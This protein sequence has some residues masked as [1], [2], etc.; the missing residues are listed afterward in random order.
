MDNPEPIVCIVCEKEIVEGDL[1]LETYRH[2]G[3]K[4]HAAMGYVKGLSEHYIA[5]DME[6]AHLEHFL[7]GNL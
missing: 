5:R 4:P 6:Y 2:T 3:V 1:F 7:K